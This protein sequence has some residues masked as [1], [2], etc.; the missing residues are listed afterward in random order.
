MITRITIISILLCEK[1]IVTMLFNLTTIWFWKTTMRIKI[2]STLR[3]CLWRVRKLNKIQRFHTICLTIIDRLF[4]FSIFYENKKNYI[5]KVFYDNN[6]LFLTN[7]TSTCELIKKRFSIIKLNKN[8]RN[9]NEAKQHKKNDEI[10]RE[11]RQNNQTL[12]RF[13]KKK[14]RSFAREKFV[15]KRDTKRYRFS[16]SFFFETKNLYK[17]WV[18]LQHLHII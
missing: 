15:R 13:T 4:K 7:D 9:N 17:R 3:R 5:T 12:L 14:Y 2:R 11:T 18:R 10:D 6:E 1:R 16:S 8:W